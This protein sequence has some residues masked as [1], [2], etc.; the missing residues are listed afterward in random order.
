MTLSVYSIG[1]NTLFHESGQ[2]LDA[3]L[4]AI[5]TEMGE[6]IAVVQEGDGYAIDHSYIFIEEIRDITLEI[7]IR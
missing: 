5:D 2:A 3:G 6:A 4:Y 1:A 7:C